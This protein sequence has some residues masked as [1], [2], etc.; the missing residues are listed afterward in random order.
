MRQGDFND[1][2]LHRAPFWQ[3][4]LRALSSELLIIVQVVLSDSWSGIS[5]LCIILNV[6]VMCLEYE[7]QETAEIFGSK[8]NERPAA[9]L[10]IA[11]PRCNVG[12]LSG[13]L[14]PNSTRTCWTPR[15][16]ASWSSSRLRW[17]SSSL[18]S[19]RP[20]TGACTACSRTPHCRPTE[21]PSSPWSADFAALAFC[22]CSGTPSPH[23]FYFLCRERCL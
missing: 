4:R 2:Q 22:C 21:Q 20:C 7:G 23:T 10:S 17:S 6:V 14:G 1:L 11:N 12:S 9:A 19:G 8:V 13:R 15:T 5:N 18:P 3:P 16:M